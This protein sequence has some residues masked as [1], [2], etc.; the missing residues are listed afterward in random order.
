MIRTKNLNETCELI[1]HFADKLEK[2]SSKPSFYDE[3]RVEKEINYCEVIKKQKKNNITEENIGEIML[4]TIPSVSNKS[5]IAIMKK[6]GT[7]TNLIDVIRNDPTCLNDIVCETKGKT[8]KIGK[9]VV[10]NIL[11]FLV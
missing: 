9:N 6:F 4:S 1:I 7:I 5:A 2:E 10:E 11:K 8:R 3:N